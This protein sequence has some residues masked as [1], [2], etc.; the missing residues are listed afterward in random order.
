MTNQ[1]G[2]MKSAPCVSNGYVAIPKA[3]SANEL[4]A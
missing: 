3:L 4:T 1:T 2:D